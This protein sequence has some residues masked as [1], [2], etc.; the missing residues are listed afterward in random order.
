MM[1]KCFFI[2]NIDLVGYSKKTEPEQYQFATDFHEKLPEFRLNP[3]F[4]VISD[5]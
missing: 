4:C 1:T 5:F 3:K 2:V